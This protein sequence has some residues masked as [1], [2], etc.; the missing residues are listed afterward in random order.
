[1]TLVILQ[2]MRPNFEKHYGFKIGDDILKTI[3]TMTG[4][5]IR[6]RNNPDKSIIC[7]DQA[8]AHATM[9][10]VTDALDEQSVKIAIGAEANINPEAVG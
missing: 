5:Y 4:R 7:L 1:M 9:R 3:I 2:N 10:G 8:C 6:N